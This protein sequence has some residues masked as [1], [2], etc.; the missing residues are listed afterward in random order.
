MPFPPTCAGSCKCQCK[1]AATIE[2]LSIIFPSLAQNRN[3]S[4][5]DLW[6]SCSWPTA[7]DGIYLHLFS[8]L[9]ASREKAQGSTQLKAMAHEAATLRTDIA[10]GR[11]WMLRDSDMLG[12]LLWEKASESSAFPAS[13]CISW[14][15]TTAEGVPCKFKNKWLQSLSVR[16]SVISRCIGKPIIT[17]FSNPGGVFG[18]EC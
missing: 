5:L 14:R 6:N 10:W 18:T 16:C 7:K 12:G 15:W 17:I 3:H 8:F 1:K 9:E 4:L 2:P 13:P 11:E